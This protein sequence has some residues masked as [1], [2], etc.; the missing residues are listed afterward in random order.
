M[1]PISKARGAIVVTGTHFARATT[2]AAQLKAM[3][4]ARA[5][6]RKIVF[7]ID[8]R[9]N[10]WGLAGHGAGEERYIKSGEVTE[11]L[12]AILPQCDLIV[13]TEEEMMIAGGADDPLGALKRGARGQPCDARAQARADGLR[14]VSRGDPRLARGRD[15]GAGLS[16]RSL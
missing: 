15:Q 16:G 2:A 3:R 14:R 6:G 4:I 1:R 8:Y 10:L 7:D 13:G 5:A 11:S 12:S 9:P